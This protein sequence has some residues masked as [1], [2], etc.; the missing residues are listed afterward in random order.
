MFSKIQAALRPHGIVTMQCCSDQD[1]ETQ[2]LLG[3]ILGELFHGIEFTTRF[4]PSFCEGWRFASARA[5]AVAA[6]AAKK[7]AGRSRRARVAFG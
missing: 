3:P 5:T 1:D 4:I 6:Q 2:K 7:P